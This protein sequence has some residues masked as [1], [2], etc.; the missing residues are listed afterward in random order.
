LVVEQPLH[1]SV[2]LAA[3]LARATAHDDYLSGEVGPLEDG[4][5]PAAALLD[6]VSPLLDEGLRRVVRDHPGA[7]R[8]VA[9]SFFIGDYAWYI[10]SGAVAAFLAE[11][12]VPDLAPQNIAL[13]YS[14]FRWEEDGES[15][16]A[17][18]IDVR[19]LSERFAALPDDSAAGSPGVLL[20][21]DGAALREWLRTALE[22]HIEP[23]TAVVTDRTRLGRRAQWNLVADAVAAVFLHAGRHVGSERSAVEDGLA[24]V[25][26]AGSPL[27]NANTGYITVEAAGHCET[28]RTRGG[29]CLFYRVKPGEHCST[30][31]LRPESERRERLHDYLAKKH[32][33]EVLA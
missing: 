14:T 3:T 25:K 4:W 32:A 28:F 8:R 33:M 29:C 7:E 10:A 1:R 5:Q 11:R 27:R 13:R 17:T 31:L 16:E 6:P 2:S 18:R 9:G 12:R 23:L 21:P 19:F 15:G 22:A 24:V 30:C 26:A 20:L